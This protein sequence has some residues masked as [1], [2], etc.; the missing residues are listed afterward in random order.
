MSTIIE[1][2]KRAN[3]STATVS[4]VIRGTRKVSADKTTRVNAA[5]RELNY[6]PNEI[7][8][9]LKVKQTRMLAMVLPDITNPFFPEII[10]GAEDAAFARGYFLLTAN[11]N[12]KVERE[13]RII[14]ALRSYRVD[15]ILLAPAQSKDTSHIA[16]MI[17]AGISVV[18]LDRTVPNVLTDAVLLDNVGGAR[19]CV[20]H[21]IDLGHRR[22]AIV[23]GALH[24]QTG[25]ERLEGYRL[26][27]KDTGLTYD[28]RLIAE[29]DFRFESGRRMGH[30]LMAQRVKPT[31]IFVC[32][33]VMAQGVLQA[34]E[35]LG[36]SCPK[37]VALA[38]F[39][40]VSTD[41][42]F[43]PHLTAVVQPSYEMGERAATILMDRIEGRLGAEWSVLRIAPKIILRGSTVP[44]KKLRLRS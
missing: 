22:I 11:T 44:P 37:D 9:S 20:R 43:H 3:V 13:Q 33:G 2:A 35:E 24:L 29:G 7:A 25:H 32:N 19:E 18:C 39:D 10:R 23:T 36:V 15:G 6:F 31:A 34:F 1:V 26:A 21:L 8:R 4:N 5:I 28:K 16:N 27:F 30:K 17:H 38:T 14:G 42:A 41:S 12:E 40:D